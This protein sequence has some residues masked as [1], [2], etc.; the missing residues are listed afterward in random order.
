MKKLIALSL[1]LIM[2]SAGLSGCSLV[3]GEYSWFIDRLRSYYDEWMYGS[4][5]SES[6]NSPL[7]VEDTYELTLDDNESGSF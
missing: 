2:V 3:N 7:T 5:N 6:T 1:S 4:E